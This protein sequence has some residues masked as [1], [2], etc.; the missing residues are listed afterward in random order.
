M[1]RK[2]KGKG[3]VV[4]KRQKTAVKAQVAR[5]QRP[6]GMSLKQG[7]NFGLQKDQGHKPTGSGLSR[8]AE[9]YAKALVNPW[10]DFDELPC[11]PYP[12]AELTKRARIIQKGT[13]TTGTTGIGSL[14]W[15]PRNAS[16]D[17]VSIW[18]SPAGNSIAAGAPFSTSLGANMSGAG[19]GS[20]PY[21]NAQL[22]T[23]PFISSRLVSSGLR[24]RC[25][26]NE[27]IAQ[28]SLIFCR[29]EDGS[30]LVPMTAA[31]L[32][33]N[34]QNVKATVKQSMDGWLHWNWYPNGDEELGLNDSAINFSSTYTAPSLGVVCTGA[35]TSNPISFDWELIEFWE[36]AGDNPSITIDSLQRTHA[37]PVGLSRVL[38][39]TV[40]PPQDLSLKG[41]AQHVAKTIIEGMAHSDSVA[42][43][44]EDMLGIVG[45][46]IPTVKSLV[47]SLTGFLLQ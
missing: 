10:G 39:G 11:V 45:L 12:P 14:G 32:G 6:A 22:N 47:T 33:S 27:M 26:A 4:S 42:K 3:R 28:G 24:I 30:S 44:V 40:V 31:L 36:F 34:L 7:L 5:Q 41:T 17:Q 20:L 2:N 23:V 38:E 29:Q 21:T 1:P 25:N 8:C 43:T 35:S 9:V 16:S 46:A 19:K 13:F 15:A 18:Y 37:D